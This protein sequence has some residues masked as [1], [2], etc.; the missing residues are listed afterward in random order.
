ML[1]HEL[2]LN[3]RWMFI[4]SAGEGT[5]GD[6]YGDDG[7]R[8]SIPSWTTGG[9]LGRHRGTCV[10]VSEYHT[11]I[12]DYKGQKVLPGYK[13]KLIMANLHL[14][15][16]DAINIWRSC[17]N[18]SCK[19]SWQ[20]LSATVSEGFSLSSSARTQIMFCQNKHQCQESLATV[21][22]CS[23]YHTIIV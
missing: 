15:L 10:Q 11:H 12:A 14:T 7:Q 8:E 13:P 1:G 4:F 19:N 18:K 6:P 9:V 22:C 2:K 17:Y 16:H 20:N 3:A 21:L 23:L 5:G